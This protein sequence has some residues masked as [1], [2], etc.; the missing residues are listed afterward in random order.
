MNLGLLACPRDRTPL[1]RESA[2]GLVCQHGHRYPVVDDVQ[3]LLLDEIGQS[4]DLARAS[5]GRALGLK[6]ARDERAP[7]L[8]LESV[9]IS[10]EEKALVLELAGR[11]DRRVDPVASVLVAATN[12]IAY[13]NLIG[14]LS[15]YPIPTLRLPPGGGKRLLDIGCSWGRWSMAAA[16][17]GYRVIGIDPS[18]GA[19]MAARR[20]ARQ[21][22]LPIDYICADGRYLPFAAD[23]FD[24]VFSYSVVQHFSKSDARQALTEVARVLVPSGNCLVQMPNKTGLR[25][26][27]HLARRK[28]SEGSGFDVRYWSLEELVSTFGK[29]IGPSSISVH[30]YFGLGLEPTDVDLMRPSLKIAIALS[31]LLRRWA[32]KAPVLTCL[33]D[34]VYLESVKTDRRDGPH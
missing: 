25:S 11:L 13:R 10:D 17:K 31:E 26:L 20:V 16:R 30:C 24:T 14:R 21:L 18:L 6:E 9:G 33:A 28:F 22:D 3:V 34:S 12:G 7:D 32:V 19:I 8:Y 15:D 29:A 4:I 1:T 23:V 5:L 27:Y 2:N